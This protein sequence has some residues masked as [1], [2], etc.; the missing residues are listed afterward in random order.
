MSKVSVFDGIRSKW[1]DLEDNIYLH[2]IPENYEY[3]KS[4]NPYKLSFL[5]FRHK[6]VRT[7]AENIF[8][9]SLIGGGYHAFVY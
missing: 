8:L 5:N 4:I 3:A 2:S 1:Q 7:R 9:I 6:K